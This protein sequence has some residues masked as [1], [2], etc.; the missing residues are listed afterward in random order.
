MTTAASC[1]GW[2]RTGSPKP[3]CPASTPVQAAHTA[4]H[5]VAATIPAPACMASVRPS[6]P[7]PSGAARQT[8][9]A[10]RQTNA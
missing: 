6:D 8:Y 3:G 1:A 5:T 10:D 2:R 7:A 4:A 9:Q